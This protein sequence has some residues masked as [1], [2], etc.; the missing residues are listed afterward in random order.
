MKLVPAEKL[1]SVLHSV[2]QYSYLK[3]KQ[4]RWCEQYNSIASHIASEDVGSF[5]MNIQIIQVNF[6]PDQLC[7][8]SVYMF[9]AFSCL[10][11]LGSKD[12]SNWH[13]PVSSNAMALPSMMEKNVSYLIK[14]M[15]IK[16]QQQELTWALIPFA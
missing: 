12:Q 3:P 4:R 15:Q 1:T 13:K 16:T 5:I 9:L 2:N 6:Y 14:C 10:H 7:D 8:V 11:D